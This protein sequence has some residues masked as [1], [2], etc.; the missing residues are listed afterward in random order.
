MRLVAATLS[1]TVLVGG[2]AFAASAA[3]STLAKRPLPPLLITVESAAE[4]IVDL[5]FAQDREGVVIAARKLKI[6][7][8]A[9][10]PVLR[11]AGAT[12]AQ[13]KAVRARVTDVVAVAQYRPFIEVAL[14]ANAVSRL[15]PGFYVRFLAPVPPAV[16]ELDYLDREAEL[17]S[18][19]GRRD[20]VRSLVDELSSTWAALRPK[21]LARGGRAE[22]SAFTSHVAA[23]KRLARAGADKLLQR[24][25]VNGLALV[26]ELEGVFSS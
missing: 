7:A 25:A 15:M 22:A 6:D 19:A 13:L 2:I 1:L 4:D 14:A 17:D 12:S 9:A 11:R 16:L 8:T 18:L 5:A 26:D 21:V 3:T 20:L 10:L 24:E 23:M